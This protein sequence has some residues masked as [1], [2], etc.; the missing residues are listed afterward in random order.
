MKISSLYI[1]VPFCLRK[2]RYCD[3]ASFVLE[4]NLEYREKY[5]DQLLQELALYGSDLDFSS[6]ETIYFGGGT[7][8]LLQAEEIAQILQ[9]FPRA[10]EITLEANPETVDLAALTSFRE[11]GINRLS[12]G[13]QSFSSDQLSAMGRGHS[14]EQATE[15]VQAA[16]KAGFANISIDLIYGLPNQS[17]ADWQDDLE[18]ALSL[19]TQHIS[20]YCLDLDNDT[21][22]GR[23]AAQGKLIAADNDLAA[24][25]LEMAIDKLK[26]AGFIHY[27]ISNFSRPGFES[28]HNIAYWQRNNYLGLGVAAAGCMAN[29]R[30][31]NQKNLAD[32][33]AMLSKGQLPYL[34]EEWLT[35]DQVIGEYLFLGLRLLAGIDFASFE[36]QFGIDARKRFKKS[37]RRL[38]DLGLLIVDDKGMR[39]SSRGV[40]LGNEVFMS[41]I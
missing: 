18:Q 31:Y 15:A 39:L 22:W 32:Y 6:L 25:M 26:Q 33:Q 19:A 37:I 35:I 29:H 17:L 8:S 12:L 13:I 21:P 34:D 28:K 23:L 3:F 4:D 40:L 10:K 30:T 14:P 2:C 5:I 38:A 16:K 36:E 27:E 7:P 24:D 41:F 11:I 1:H 20:L 9:K